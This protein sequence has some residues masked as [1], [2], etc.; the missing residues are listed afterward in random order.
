MMVLPKR[1]Q[2]RP[3]A[4]NEPTLLYESDSEPEGEA[5]KESAAR[6]DSHHAID[7]QT[8]YIVRYLRENYP[9]FNRFLQKLRDV[10]EVRANRSPGESVEET[11]DN[12]QE[13]TTVKETDATLLYA[14]AEMSSTDDEGDSE[15]DANDRKIEVEETPADAEPTMAY[16]TE[17]LAKE[18]STD[19]EH[20][21][22][23]AAEDYGAD[24]ATQAYAV[25]SD[26][27]PESEPIPLKTGHAATEGDAK[28]TSKT[29]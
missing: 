23:E 10:K 6:E 29:F 22:D 21:N 24:M 19:D 14:A 3:V 9:V 8:C 11:P 27:E 28:S 17:E 7:D 26:S 13:A 16:N 20:D 4:S 5:P 18:D 1:N 15:A 12:K 2:D 25:G